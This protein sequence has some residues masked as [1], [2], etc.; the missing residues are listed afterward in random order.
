MPNRVRNR[1]PFVLA[2]VGAAVWAF[3][4]L[5]PQLHTWV[6]SYG[7]PAW[8]RAINDLPV[9]DGLRA[10]L[11]S[12]GLT[13]H[14]AV[15][16]A[17][18]APSFVLLAIAFRPVTR[19]L[20]LLGGVLYWVTL[21][22]AVLVVL[23]YLTHALPSPWNALWG[24]EALALAVIGLL[25]IACAILAL[26]RRVRPGWPAVMLMLLLPIAV[27]STLLFGYWPHGSLILMGLWVA[28]IAYG[29]P[30]SAGDHR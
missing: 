22:S 3:F 20:G 24:S 21:L 12:V 14:Y 4:L 17:A 26:V 11:D 29:W 10:G 30:G 7:M 6:T 13:D 23:S 16:G 2:G 19:T 18:I 1:L 25:A 8:L 5:P 27:A 15:F 28:V 9:Y